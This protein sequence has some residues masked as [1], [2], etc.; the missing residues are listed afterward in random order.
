MGLHQMPAT[1]LTALSLGTLAA[2]A[3]VEDLGQG[4]CSEEETGDDQGIFEVHKGIGY[5]ECMFKCEMAVDID[6][7]WS[8]EW[9]FGPLSCT[10]FE[11]KGEGKSGKCVLLDSAIVAASMG[12]PTSRSCFKLIR[13]N[14]MPTPNTVFGVSDPD[15]ADFA[16]KNANAH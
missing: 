12:N 14:G 10:G 5:D 8:A 15:K 9:G 13:G 4:R 16:L 7:A 11:H 2:A 1:S 3:S 6:P